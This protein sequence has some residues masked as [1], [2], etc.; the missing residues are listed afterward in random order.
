M[1]MDSA[2][3]ARPDS[4]LPTISSSWAS[5]ASKLSAFTSSLSAM[6]KIL[7]FQAPGDAVLQHGDV[8]RC[9]PGQSLQ[10]IATFEQRDNA[11]AA[12][13]LGRIHQLSREPGEVGRPPV[14]LGQRIAAMRIESGREQQ[15]VRRE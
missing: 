6:A 13:A 12:T 5:A 4:S 9:A 3:G 10:V 7:I 1:A 15:Q 14:E 11:V 2:S 8:V